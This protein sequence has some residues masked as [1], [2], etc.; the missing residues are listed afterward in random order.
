[1]KLVPFKLAFL[2]FLPLLAFP[3][4]GAKDNGF[5]SL[6]NGKDL[7]QWILPQGDHTWKIVDG[8]VDF[9]GG[10]ELGQQSEASSFVEFQAI[11]HL[12]ARPLG[13]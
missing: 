12:L 1:M 9:G 5:V 10:L 4:L 7:D 11:A 3:V 8:V 13:R 2:P 6:F